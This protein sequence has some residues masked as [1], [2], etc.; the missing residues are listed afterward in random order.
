[1]KKVLVTYTYHD[2]LAALDAKESAASFEVEDAVAADMVAV[3]K[4]FLFNKFDKSHQQIS[5]AMIVYWIAAAH[6]HFILKN[7]QVLDVSLS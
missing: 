7:D 5:I 6:D 1:M 2:N 4:P 3:E